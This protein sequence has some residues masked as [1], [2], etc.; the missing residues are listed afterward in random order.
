ME[1]RPTQLPATGDAACCEG[2]RSCLRKLTQQPAFF[3][4]PSDADK[5]GKRSY[6]ILSV[7]PDNLTSGICLA[8]TLLYLKW[9]V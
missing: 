4:T 3:Y 5:Q 6:E 1:R 9:N 8:R 2:Q 7:M